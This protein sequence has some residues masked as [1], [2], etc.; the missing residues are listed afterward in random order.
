EVNGIS[1]TSALRLTM[2][3]FMRSADQ[4]LALLATVNIGLD[5][6]GSTQSPGNLPD[7]DFVSALFQ[8]QYARL[9]ANGAQLILRGDVQWTNDPLLPLEQIAIG[10]AN[11][12]RGYR[13]NETV[14]DKG[15]L[16]SAQY[17]YPL[18]EPISTDEGWGRLDLVLFSDYGRASNVGR[19]ASPDRE[20]ISV[21]A[22][23]EWRFRDF[24]ELDLHVAHGIGQASEKPDHNLQDEG[25][26][27]R[28]TVFN[29]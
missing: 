22:G 15:Y 2:D 20:L 16:L 4:V 13:E 19:N 8:V 24:L 9:L 5:K 14:S 1:K 29:F 3:G 23:L 28:L 7:S 27:L 17:Q 6:W 11:T 25:V 10:G 18:F 26:H 21:G 12:V